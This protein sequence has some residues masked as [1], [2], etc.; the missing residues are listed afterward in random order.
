MRVFAIGIEHP[1]DVAVQGS[2]DADTR[3]HRRAIE[4]DDQE[5]GFDRNVERTLTDRKEMQ[6]GRRKLKR[7]QQ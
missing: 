2:H 1:F 6:W 3:K 7:D 5:Q 4:F